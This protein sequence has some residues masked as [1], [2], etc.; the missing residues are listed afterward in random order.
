MEE[1]FRWPYKASRANAP[2]FILH[3]INN[4]ISSFFA[5]L[6]WPPS[7]QQP[8]CCASAT[9]LHQNPTSHR[10]TTPSKQKESFRIPSKKAGFSRNWL[11][12][13]SFDVL[14]LFCFFDNLLSRTLCER[15]LT[16]CSSQETP[17]TSIAKKPFIEL[18]L[19]STFQL[20]FHV[21]RQGLEAE[22]MR[23]ARST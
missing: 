15:R 22:P 18:Q 2:I 16:C 6:S 7:S 9:C 11:L 19:A 10:Q 17:S 20:P 14:L 12:H 23:T 5:P 1:L 8:K 4:T 13:T 21:D 3:T